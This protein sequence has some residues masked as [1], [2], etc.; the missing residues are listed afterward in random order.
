MATKIVFLKKQKFSNAILFTGL[1]GIG[2]VGKICVDY[3]LKQFKS[4]KLAEIISDTF[5][6]SVHTKEAILELIKDEFFYFNFKGQDFLFLAGPVQPSLDF[7]FGSAKEHYEFAEK[8]VEAA[9]AFGV[10]QIITLAGINIG[11]KRLETPPNVIV[12]ATSQKTLK[13]FSD[14]GA[15]A[16]KKEGLISGAA[17][18]VLGIAKSYGIEGACLMG[19]TNARLIYGDHGAAKKII[20]LIVKKYGFKVGM[21]SIEKEAKS[22]EQAFKQLAKQFEEVEEKMPEESPSYIR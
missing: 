13:E 17:G 7:R 5:P 19:E 21:Q 4:E 18:L 16:D 8:I 11:D 3:L 22:I 2:L 9:Q 6:P 20:E 15:I 10:K 14:I 12:A 1:P